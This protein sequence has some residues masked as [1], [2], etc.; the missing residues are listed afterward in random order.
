[1]LSINLTFDEAYQMNKL[2]ETMLDLD[3]ID[4]CPIEIENVFD[5]I[6]EAQDSNTFIDVNNTG[7]KY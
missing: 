4:E 3:M 6:R 1:M 2:Y 7:G 5:K